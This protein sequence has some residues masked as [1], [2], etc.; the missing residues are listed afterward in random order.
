MTNSRKSYILTTLFILFLLFL[1]SPNFSLACSGLDYTTQ[2]GEHESLGSCSDITCP[3]ECNGWDLVGN[4]ISYY[5]PTC[6]Q[7]TCSGSW[8]EYKASTKECGK[9]VPPEEIVE[10]LQKTCYSICGQGGSE[11]CN[12]GGCKVECDDAVQVSGE[13]GYCVSWQKAKR[14]GTCSDVTKWGLEKPVCVC[15]GECIK[16]PED[17]RYYDNP[18]LEYPT[19]STADPTNIFLPVKLAWKDIRDGG[20]TRPDYPVYVIKIENTYHG[21]NLNLSIGGASFPPLPAPLLGNPLVPG[22]PSP[23]S[24]P[25]GS[26]PPTYPPPTTFLPAENGRFNWPSE[27]RWITSCFGE[28][29]YGGK[30]Y[31]HRAIDIGTSGTVYAAAAGTVTKVST[32]C[33]NHGRIAGDPDD[34]CTTDPP[35]PGC[36]YSCS[37]GNYLGNRVDIE[38]EIDGNTFTTKYGHMVHGSIPISVG[39]QVIAGQSIGRA[40]NTGNSWGHHIHFVILNSAGTPVDPLLYLPPPWTNGLW[41]DSKWCTVERY[42]PSTT[43]SLPA[44]SLAALLKTRTGNTPGNHSTKSLAVLLGDA[45]EDDPGEVFTA[46]FGSNSFIAGN[47]LLKPGGTHPWSVKACCGR[48]S[49]EDNQTDADTRLANNAQCGTTSATWSFTNNWAPEPVESFDPDWSGEN[50]TTTGPFQ[51]VKLPLKRANLRWYPSDFKSEGAEGPMSYKILI[52]QKG[53]GEVWHPLLKQGD[54]CVPYLLVPEPGSPSLYPYPEFLNEEQ[55]YFTKDTSYAWKVAACKDSNGLDCTDYSQKWKFDT[56]G[57]L[58]APF[59]EYP[60]NEP[61]GEIP[62]G[63]PIVFRWSGSFGSASFHYEVSDASSIIRTGTTTLSNFTLDISPLQLNKKYHWKVQPCWDMEATKCENVWAESDF[64]TTG[65]PPKSESMKARKLT[66]IF[67]PVTFEWENVSGAKS[68]I[69]KVQG[70]GLDFTTTTKESS[71]VLDYPDLHQEKNYS[72][73]VKTCARENGTVCGEWSEIKSFNTLK[74]SAPLNPSPSNGQE[75]FTYEG[76]KNFSWDS[77]SG[78]RY[79]KYILN[80]VSKSP[81]ET[82]DCPTGEIINKIIDRNSNI[83][84]LECLGGYQWQVQACLDKDCNESGDLSSVWSLTLSQKEG[85]GKG[86]LVPC[87][88]TYDNPKTPWNEREP[89]QI[90]HLFILLRSILDFLFWEVGLLVLVLLAI[91]TAVIYYFSMGAPTTVI[92]VRAIWRAA[93]IGYA[94]IFLAWLIINLFL[95]ILGYKFQIF[96]HWW[97]IKL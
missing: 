81:E 65:R 95:A 51:P 62:V 18:Q 10:I 5:N 89:C 58:E 64:W 28:R 17:P 40:D 61:T 71:Y 94:I 30:T 15:E 27:N 56:T 7:Y 80:Y 3:E 91:F 69:F 83:V 48:P 26:S 39:D 63:L 45:I 97:Q 78:A 86:G 43:G 60:P 70:D 79:Y 50:E 54:E 25:P 19:S 85:A 14:T 9:D 34:E 87:G 76:P 73:Q 29:T 42:H 74:L 36:E 47:G 90:K 46:T 96:G 24:F 77:V 82:G 4:C 22:F 21:L 59:L 35:D 44:K 53:S 67:I 31:M 20:E 2:C 93:G 6:T 11:C 52:Y 55:A 84:I 68:F 92:N 66:D 72:W 8:T 32:D 33:F 1:I 38:S 41:E 23:G 57:T 37:G 12:C 88:R 75:V 49:G 16:T 13:E